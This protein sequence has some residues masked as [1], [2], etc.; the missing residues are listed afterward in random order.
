MSRREALSRLKAREPLYYGDYLQLDK[1]LGAQ[2][3]KSA[4]A[5]AEAHDEHLFL[6]IHQVYELWFK[7]ILHEL[8]S[9][10]K[11]LGAVPVDERDVGIAVDRLARVV[12]IQ[13]I[14]LQQVDVLETM[15]PLDF[16][17]FRDYLYPASGFQ[18]VQFRL[19]GV[20]WLR[21]RERACAPCRA[22]PRAAC[23]VRP[24][25]VAQRFP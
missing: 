17:D 23:G 5:G 10:E 7:Q 11:L 24:L 1:I 2:A 22:A 8:S 15:S 4:A 6:V 9:V 19:I 14:L 18:S 20:C 21:A 3:L 13:K 12:T 16:L 25:R